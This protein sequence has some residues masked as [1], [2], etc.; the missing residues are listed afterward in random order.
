MHSRVYQLPFPL[1]QQR[2]RPHTA[3]VYHKQG[4]VS[5]FLAAFLRRFATGEEG[6]DKLPQG[7][8]VSYCIHPIAAHLQTECEGLLGQVFSSHASLSTVTFLVW[9][10]WVVKCMWPEFIYNFFFLGAGS[11]RVYVSCFIPDTDRYCG[12]L[13]SVG[14]KGRFISRQCQKERLIVEKKIGEPVS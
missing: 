1:H 12:T 7:I 9:G 14:T 8:W 3:L 2:A 5:G 13:R 4:A 11:V 10:C 6:A